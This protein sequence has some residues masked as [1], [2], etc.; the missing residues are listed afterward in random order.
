MNASI[1]T[2]RPLASGS[3]PAGLPGVTRGGPTGPKTVVGD[4]PWRPPAVVR[5]STK[6]L[7]LFEVI[8]VVTALVMLLPLRSAMREQ[9]IEDMQNELIAIAATTA[10]QLDGDRHLAVMTDR[11]PQSEAFL[12]LQAQLRAIQNANGLTDDNLYTLY[13]G[14]GRKLHFGVMTTAEPFIGDAIDMEPHHFELM[15][16][17]RPAAYGPYDDPHGSW[18][19]AV[20]PIIDSQGAITGMVEVAHRSETYFTRYNQVIANVAS[21]G[22]IG[23]GLA[24][25]LGL[26]V[27]NHMI[28]KPVEQI[29]RGM[30]ALHRQDFH[31]RVKIATGDELERLGRTLNGLFEQL[32]VARQIQAGFFPARLPQPAGYRL[33]AVSDPCDATGGDYYDAFTIDDRHTAIVVADVTGHGLGP[34]LLMATCRS[35]LNALSLAGHEPAD[36]LDRLEQILLRDLLE[37]RFI[38]LIYGVLRD[39]GRFAYCNAGH[40]PAMI[41]RQGRIEQLPSHRPPLGVLLEME[42]DDP[43]QSSIQLEPGDRILFASDGVDEA[44]NPANAQFG[45]ASLER[46]VRETTGD[47]E[48]VLAALRDALG[49]HRAGRPADDDVTILCVERLG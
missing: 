43:R 1:A 42:D 32:N 30:E 3:M 35:A 28:L 34:S 6:L 20:A 33:A 37:G 9:V 49:Q 12:T 23:L 2:D 13:F 27:L 16:T 29:R 8:L 10:S 45:R 14:E 5:L 31:H 21:T 41:L 24:S 44:R 19:S 38:T 17:G 46:I 7:I 36:M 18:I 47:C 15:R 22:L 40:G 48:S 26:L 11:D 25:L 4:R 39:D